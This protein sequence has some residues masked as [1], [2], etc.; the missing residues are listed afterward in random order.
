[1]FNRVVK[2]VFFRKLKDLF[3][4]EKWNFLQLLQKSFFYSVCLVR[5]PVSLPL[6]VL[7]IFTD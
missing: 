6:I 4:V 3:P 5:N 2:Y 7:Y 1:M